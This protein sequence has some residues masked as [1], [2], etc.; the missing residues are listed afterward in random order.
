MGGVLVRTED[1]APREKL[2]RRLGMTYT[3]LGNVIFNSDSARQATIGKMTTEEHWEYVREKLG[4]TKDEFPRVPKDFWGGDCLDDDLVNYVRSLRPAYKTGLLSNAWD[5]LRGVLTDVWGIDDAF[6]QI[7]I[8][9]EVGVAKP[10]PQIY[11]I[12]LER[13]GVLPGEAVFVDDFIENVHAARAL[14]IQ[15]VHFQEPAEAKAELENLLNSK[16]DL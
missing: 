15:A 9:A 3:E 10:D 2:A 8:S 6:D 5:D 7:I 1:R 14:D 16:S 11:Y 13:L 4:L 12:A